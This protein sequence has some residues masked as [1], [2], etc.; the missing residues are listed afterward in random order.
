M[1]VCIG[2]ECRAYDSVQYVQERS[3]ELMAVCN[4][5]SRGVQRE[6]QCVGGYGS[7]Q[8]ECRRGEQRGR[9]Y[10]VSAGEECRGSYSMEYVQ[11]R[12]RWY[13]CLQKR[14]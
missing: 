6:L 10:A 1:A 5:Y 12:C 4:M 2:E 8:C 7:M 13:V 3:A 14:V 11:E 9:Q